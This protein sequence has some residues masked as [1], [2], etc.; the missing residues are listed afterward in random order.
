MDV[1]AT[2]TALVTPSSTPPSDM[3]LR[4]RDLVLRRQSP[5]INVDRPND[6]VDRPEYLEVVALAL[7][8]GRTETICCVRFFHNHDP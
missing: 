7:V 1:F 3:G 6:L 4:P 5:C 2:P 8:C